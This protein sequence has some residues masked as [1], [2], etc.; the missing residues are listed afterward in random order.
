MAIRDA[1][2]QIAAGGGEIQ[3]I[4]K[5]A[6]RRQSDA[7]LTVDFS[8]LEANTILP[9]QWRLGGKVSGHLVYTGDLDRFE[10]G[11]VVGSVKI[12]GATFDMANLFGTLHQLAKFGGL[13][14]VRIDSIEAHVRNQE[15]ELQLSDIRASYQDQIRVEGTGLI[16]PDYLSRRLAPGAFSK[17]PRVDSRL[18]KK[19]YSRSKENYCIGSR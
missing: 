10:H 15:R 18:P 11:E 5:V 12:S 3:V 2:A 7:Q 4:G 6:I 19:M 17:N 1:K 16:A 13:D 8:D 9:A 14:D